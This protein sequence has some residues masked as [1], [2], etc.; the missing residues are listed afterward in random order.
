MR[1]PRSIA[2]LSLATVAVLGLSACS[3]AGE[4]EPEAD[5]PAA[6]ASA[7][8]ETEEAVEVDP[9]DLTKDDFVQ[10]LTAATQAAGSLRMEMATVAAG[11]TE[12]MT[13]AVRYG[14]GTPD[15]VMSGEVPDVGTMDVRMV[16]GMLYMSLGALTDGKFVQID[17]ADPENGFGES[18]SELQEGFDPTGTLDG[19]EG[20]IV[21]V[22]KAGEP[23]EVGGALAQPYTVV[24][25]TSVLSGDL[26][27]DLAES[28]AALPP[29]LSYAY[30]VDA[31]DRMRR[32]T[33]EVGG[34]T[35]TSTFSAWG[36]PVDIAAP[37]PD[38]ITTEMP[39]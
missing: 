6:E 8:A 16:G 12:T 10:R 18:F 32:V 26:A 9:F 2:A 22:D 35:T 17:P 33:T 15:F 30:W 3:S 27:A 21:S 5:R 20:A 36:E 23:E 24:V 19:L 25:D 31:D 1:V 28:G 34:V 13:G 39:F 14:G 37:A 7:P 29:Q 11:V 38:Q 4:A